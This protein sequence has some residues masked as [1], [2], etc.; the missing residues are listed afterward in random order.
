MAT[1]YGSYLRCGKL[2]GQGGDLSGFTLEEDSEVD[3]IP[4][5]YSL[6]AE[7]D[8][9]A[10]VCKSYHNTDATLNCIFSLSALT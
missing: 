1:I 7:L 8:S 6:C 5:S 3:W 10:S 2:E 4:Y 9:P